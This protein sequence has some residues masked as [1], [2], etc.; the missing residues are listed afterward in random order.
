MLGK[1]P[2]ER[3]KLLE[4]NIKELK[5]TRELRE[6][7]FEETAHSIWSLYQAYM[8]AGFDSIQALEIVKARGVS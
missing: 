6:M 7:M 2:Q 8:K 4:E 1:N 3:R 5:S